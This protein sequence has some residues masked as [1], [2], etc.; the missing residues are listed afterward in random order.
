MKHQFGGSWTDQKLDTVE[1]YLKAY[2]LIFDRNPQARFYQTTYV[3]GFAGTVYRRESSDQPST[4]GLF[5]VSL[6]DEASAL[7]KG[8]ALRALDVEP[9]FDRYVLIEQRE[10]HARDLESLR[11]DHPDKAERIEIVRGDCNELIRSWCLEK[12]WRKNRALV[13]LDPYGMQVEWKTV[14]AI[15][16]TKAID[17]W[18]LFPLGQSVNRLLTRA[19]PP[20]PV[21]ADRLTTTFGTEEWLEAFYRTDVQPGLFG[22]IEETRRDATTLRIGEFFVERLKSIFAGVAEPRPLR[23]S[24]NNPIYL[25]CFAAGNPKGAK[26]AVKIANHLLAS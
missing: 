7:K 5:E 9:G 23:N 4:S 11:Q 2:T 6:D 17:L 10:A 21:W 1:K 14:D 19:E 12:N 25:L 26:T 22:D 18:L 24:K 20:P 8:S 15:A 16:K 3:D 13:F